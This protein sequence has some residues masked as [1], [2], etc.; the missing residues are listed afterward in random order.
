VRLRLTELLLAMSELT[1]AELELGAAEA[2]FRDVQAE[3]LLSRCQ[4]LRHAADLPNVP[5]TN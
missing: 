3:T 4:T 2:A 1:G 5:R